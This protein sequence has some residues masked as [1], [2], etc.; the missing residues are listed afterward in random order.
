ML[1]A[2]ATSSWSSARIIIIYNMIHTTANVI[3]ITLNSFIVDA[4]VYDL[5]VQYKCHKQGVGFSSF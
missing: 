2:S 4:T 5:D 1:Y 3:C